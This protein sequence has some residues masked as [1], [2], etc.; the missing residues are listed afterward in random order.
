MNPSRIH[1][2]LQFKSAWRIRHG[3]WAEA[4][5]PFDPSKL[6]ATWHFDGKPVHGIKLWGSLEG[7]EGQKIYQWG[8][9]SRFAWLNPFNWNKEELWSLELS[10]KT[11][12]SSVNAKGNNMMKGKVQ[13]DTEKVQEFIQVLDV[14]IK[15]VR[16]QTQRLGAKQRDLK[17]S[18][19]DPQYQK[20]SQ[21]FEEAARMINRYLERSEVQK[22]E[23]RKKIATLDPYQG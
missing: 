13:I 16:D 2:Q 11:V 6:E 5:L 22:V 4:E 17:A 1:V 15:T 19:N 7:S 10:P 23:L 12:S 9:K 14:F 21:E 3:H 8:I 18:W 20:F